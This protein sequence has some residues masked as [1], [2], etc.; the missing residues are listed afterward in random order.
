MNEKLTPKIDEE[1]QLVDVVV[2]Q[3]SNEIAPVLK[4]AP[5]L[6]VEQIKYMARGRFIDLLEKDLLT[7]REANRCYQ[8]FVQMVSYYYGS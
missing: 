4:E 1:T 3:V 6:S 2:K 7:E 8:R 5:N